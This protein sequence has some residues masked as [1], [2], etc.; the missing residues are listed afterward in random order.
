[1]NLD[2]SDYIPGDKIPQ[3][4]VDSIAPGRFGSMVRMRLLEEVSPSQAEKAAVDSKRS[5]E[6]KAR[7]E[8][9]PVCGERFKNL[10]GHVKKMHAP[11]EEE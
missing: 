5:S 4:V 10:A 7:R 8:K 11:Q 3:S 2:G 1:M 9:C 6:A